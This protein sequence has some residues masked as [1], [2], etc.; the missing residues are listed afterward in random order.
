M[1]FGIDPAT[2]RALH[3]AIGDEQEGI[4]FLPRHVS[5]NPEEFP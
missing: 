5:D 2:G 1:Q 4:P 3:K